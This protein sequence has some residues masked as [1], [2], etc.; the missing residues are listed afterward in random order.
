M[1]MRSYFGLMAGGLIVAALCRAALSWDGAIYLFE[2][3]DNQRPYAPQQRLINWPLDW[4]VILASRLTSDLPLLAIIFGLVYVAFKLGL[5][6]AA[7]WVVR[8]DAPTLF[9]WAALGLGL[10]MLPGQLYFVAEGNLTVQLA[11]PLVLA[12]LMGIRRRHITLVV[13]LTIAL[14]VSHPL[15]IVVFVVAAALAWVGGWRR[16]SQRRWLWGWAA[17]FAGVAV[18]DAL[19]FLVF[20]SSYE[21]AQLSPGTLR[22]AFEG[23][24]AGRPLLALICAGV[25]A[26]LA[27]ALPL[28]NRRR[29]TPL[30]RMVRAGE[31]AAIGVATLLLL[32]WAH[33]VQAWRLAKE[34]HRFGLFVSFAFM[35]LAAIEALGY[36]PPLRRH[37]AQ[38]WPQRVRTMQLLAGAFALVLIVQSVAWLNLSGTLQS[39]VV[40][41]PWTCVS[42]APLGAIK[43]TA[44]DDW[45]SAYQTLIQEG[46]TPQQIALADDSCGQADL[47]QAQGPRF[48]P[49]LDASIVRPWGGGWFALGVV[50]QRLAQEQL[51]SR[52]WFQ[53]TSGWHTTE[54]NGAYWWRWS[55][56]SN[57][58]IR[59]VIDRD[60]QV[61]LG[62]Q[63]ETA[64]QPNRIDVTVNGQRVT[65][66]DIPTTGL[67]TLD[68]VTLQLKAG[69]NTIQLVSQNPPTPASVDNRPLAMSVANLTMTADGAAGNCAFHP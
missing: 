57:A 36:A 12:I 55:E 28:L 39:A 44:L 56:G 45:T 8:D 10:G 13:A 38:F 52:C 68:P 29:Q 49:Y 14:V 60:G 67:R 46:R 31:A 16:S 62:G 69:T 27:L 48:N 66:V 17:A 15:A 26:L 43:G 42:L 7:W 50:Q 64:R 41:S 54:T 53:L 1:P 32:L 25:A 33:D 23:A 24:V 21:S 35:A 37:V 4:P 30:S 34:Y 61:I 51:S 59:V 3:L 18:V 2:L 40:R 19:R 47:A 11:W 6:A 65:S 22:Y 58:Q 9:L 63:I 20:R 5:L